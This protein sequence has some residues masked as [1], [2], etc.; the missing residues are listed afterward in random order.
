MFR[1]DELMI[2]ENLTGLS[3]RSSGL[4]RKSAADRLLGLRFRVLPGKWKSVCCECCVLAGREI[5]STG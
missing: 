4:R 2:F 1:V 3:L 5:S